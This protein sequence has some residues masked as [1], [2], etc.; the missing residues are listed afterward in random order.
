[1]SELDR[2]IQRFANRWFDEPMVWKSRAGS[3]RLRVVAAVM[4]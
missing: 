3:T 2:F 4:P 1:M